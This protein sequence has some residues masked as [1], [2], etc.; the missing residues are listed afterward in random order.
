MLQFPSKCY[1]QYQSRT[2]K[3]TTNITTLQDREMVT[4]QN[5]L[6]LQPLMHPENMFPFNE[7]SLSRAALGEFWAFIWLTNISLV[8]SLF[9]PVKSITLLTPACVYVMFN[10]QTYYFLAH[11][12][13]MSLFWLEY[14]VGMQHFLEELCSVHNAYC[15][16][17]HTL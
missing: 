15:F 14:Q 10:Q 1:V 8:N 16:F 3:F 6:C 4:F 2:H 5:V 9:S 12:Y 11:V 13:I 7:N 17:L